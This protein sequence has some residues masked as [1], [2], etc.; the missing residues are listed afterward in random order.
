MGKVIR[1]ELQV[2]E[3]ENKQ[4]REATHNSVL[5]QNIASCLATPMTLTNL[6]I[7]LQ[8]FTNNYLEPKFKAEVR[9]LRVSSE[10]RLELFMDYYEE[11][12]RGLSI[13]ALLFSLAFIIIILFIFIPKVYIRNHIYYVSKK[14]NALANQHSQLQSE[15]A[16]L[17]RQL[18]DLHFLYNIKN[19][20]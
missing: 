14:I 3:G 1:I 8:S 5:S 19:I 4:D 11:E 7:I 15:N 13:N 16:S 20:D 6:C 10:E 18:Q 12:E 9:D 17:E 2:K